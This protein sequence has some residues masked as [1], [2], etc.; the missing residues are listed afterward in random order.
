MSAQQDVSVLRATVKAISEDLASASSAR[1]MLED[2]LEAQRRQLVETKNQLDEALA[3]NETLQSDLDDAN[4]HLN[5][6]KA[7][8]DEL[9]RANTEFELKL[10]EADSSVKKVK[11]DTAKSVSEKLEGK[12]EVVKAD[13]DRLKAEL[14]MLEQSLADKVLENEQHK[15]FVLEAQHQMQK[16]EELNQKMAKELDSLRERDRDRVAELEMTNTLSPDQANGHTRNLSGSSA[17]ISIVDLSA[18]EV[19]EFDTSKLKSPQAGPSLHIVEEVDGKNSS[20]NQDEMK[21]QLADLIQKQ[22]DYEAQISSLQSALVDLRHERDT[23]AAERNALKKK[24]ASLAKDMDKIIRSKD[25]NFLSRSVDFSAQKSSTNEE[26]ERLKKEHA[27]NLAAL[28]MYK[29]AFE[30]QVARAARSGSAVASGH[31][32]RRTVE[33]EMLAKRLTSTLAERD[34]EIKHLKEVAELLQKQLSN[35]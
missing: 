19:V 21:S 4:Q 13:R 16:L 11:K 15:K 20:S 12:L 10:R 17:S 24:A 2:E 5:S 25:E 27:E 35:K 1:K 18:T 7:V 26:L 28:E 29:K 22:L 3:V 34:E 6:I 9:S 8:K 31:T 32:D 30:E 23:L 33:M 14:G